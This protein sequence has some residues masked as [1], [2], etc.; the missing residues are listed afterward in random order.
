M[1]K[2]LLS[3]ILALFLLSTFGNS[4]A[5]YAG[6]GGNYGS[7][8]DQLKSVNTNIKPAADNVY[9]L[10]SASARWRNGYFSGTAIFAEIATSGNVGLGSSTPTEKL[11]VVGNVKVSGAIDTS[12]INDTI[13]VDGATYPLTSTG[14]NAALTNGGRMLIKR[15]TSAISA[16]LAVSQNKTNIQGDGD[17]TILTAGAAL[18]AN[19]ITVTGSGV[20]FNDFVIQGAKTSQTTDGVGIATGFSANNFNATNIEIDDVYS[21]GLYWNGSKNGFFSNLRFNDTGRTGASGSKGAGLDIASAQDFVVSGVISKNS[22][23]SA[24][25]LSNDAVY[26]NEFFVLHGILA[27]NVLLDQQSGVYVYRGA[28]GVVHGVVAHDMPDGAYGV[29]GLMNLGDWT[30]WADSV[31]YDVSG[32]GFETQGDNVVGANLLI[33]QN[34]TGSDAQG[35]F[36]AGN[37]TNISN[38]IENPVSQHGIY[39]GN[40]DN[41]DVSHVNVLS[42]INPSVDKACF[43]HTGGGD[44]IRYTD[45]TCDDP[46]GNILRGVH[47]TGAQ[48][49]NFGM[50]G[51]Y[52][53]RVATERIHWETAPTWQPFTADSGIYI[54]S[55]EGY[56]KL[57]GSF[58]TSNTHR[59]LLDVDGSAYFSGNVGINTSVPSQ[60]LEV[61]GIIKTSV[62]IYNS[63][64][65]K[66]QIALN[67]GGSGFGQIGNAINNTWYLGY[68]SSMTTG[69]TAVLSWN[70]SGNVGIGSSAPQA[71]LDVDG[72]VY[73]KPQSGAPTIDNTIYV[74]DAHIWAILGGSVKRLDN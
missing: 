31:I 62:A 33:K 2:N 67:H 38:V 57:G 46:N 71:K 64:L 11:D 45:S 60:S 18:N 25:F 37:G 13:Y 12:N 15:G 44:N 47:L 4:Y 50:W 61:A 63:A 39:I 6:S 20:K 21:T 19:V 52:I 14:L 42:A 66:N 41:I 3:F 40:V 8:L 65:E 53:N 1:L 55:S 30:V 59:A 26:K 27:S 32:N 29:N 22:L 74:K 73:L 68:G 70:N 34:G 54:P 28:K 51:N 36:I 16:S 69:G 17:T 7:M 23:Y 5:D 10:G 9:D 35:V 72:A 56:M 48:L 58:N 43:R 49:T 24:L